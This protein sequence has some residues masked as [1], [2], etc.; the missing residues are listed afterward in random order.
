MHRR[1][2]TAALIALAVAALG[3]PG[4]ATANAPAG[5]LDP[6]FGT[7]GVTTTDFAGN[8]DVVRGLALQ[9]DG[10]LVTGGITT[11]VVAGVTNTDFGLARYLSDGSLDPTFGAGGRV[12]T[13]FGSA[14]EIWGIALETDGKIVAA[15]RTGTNIAVARYNP[16]GSL[17]PTFGA[18]GK[19]VTDL[20][21]TEVA[22]SVAIQPDGKLLV[23]GQTGGDFAV[24]R[25]N[26]DGSLDTGFGSSG[27]VRTDF[28]GGTDLARTV[29]VQPDGKIV[30][31]GRTQLGSTVQFALARYNADGS[32]DPT[33]GTGGLVTTN[34]NG[35]AFAAVMEG[36]DLVVVGTAGQ[37]VVDFAVVRYLPDGS[38]DPGFGSGGIVTTDFGTA[39]DEAFAVALDG[40][41]RIV[42]AGHAGFSFALARYNEHG[43][44][45]RNF[46]T[47]GRVVTDITPGDDEARGVVIQPDG[48]IVAAG[49]SNN[50]ADFAI[51]RYIGDA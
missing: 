19:V 36:D 3:A 48:R 8:L 23:A 31:A 39:S 10:K 1:C 27:V 49:R 40:E 50:N 17:D 46:G 12:V 42:V 33:F 15:G 14:D 13:E 29:L 47:D 2:V 18:G 28:G 20:G 11:S 24:V 9:P 34:L 26:A 35:A 37:A 6:N 4:A 21:S 25:Y 16:D 41:G 22:R 43:T 5:G 32:L 44:L 7:S 45:T 51:A 30:V 38:L